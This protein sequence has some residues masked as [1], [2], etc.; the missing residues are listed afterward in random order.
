MSFATE[1]TATMSE[2]VGVPYVYGGAR[3]LSQAAVGAQTDC[4]GAVIIACDHVDPGCTGGASYTGDMRDKFVATGCW[5]WVQGLEG[6]R[7]GDVLLTPKAGGVVGHTAVVASGGGILEEYPPAG[8][9]VDWYDYPWA[10]YLRHVLNETVD[11]EEEDMV[12]YESAWF[13]V[14]DALNVRTAPSTDAEVV[15]VYEP[16]AVVH[17]DGMVYAQGYVWGFYTG[18]DSGELRYVAVG[19]VAFTERYLL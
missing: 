17:V 8:R 7:A 11:G 5:R 19:P 15:A 3:P 14:Q 13:T 9:L 12:K 18:E 6:V 4:S 1:L 16:G 10:G 2:W